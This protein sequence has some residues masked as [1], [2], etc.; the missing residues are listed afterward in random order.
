MRR[1]I[2]ILCALLLSISAFAQVRERKEVVKDIRGGNKAYEKENYEAA[3]LLYRKAL[4]KN[5]GSFDASYNLA[6][7]EYKKKNYEAAEKRYSS[8][9]DGT[10]DNAKKASTYHN[11]GN[12][13]LNQKKYEESIAAYKKAL[14][15]HP[16]DMDTKSNLAY[17]QKMLQKNGGGGGGGNNQQDKQNQQDKNQDKNQ[18]DQNQ[19]QNQQNQDQQ[20]DKNQDQNQDQQQQ[21]G[22]QNQPKMSKQQAEQLLEAIQ[23]DDR[24]TQE[25]VNKEKAR[26]VKQRSIEKNW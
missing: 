22:Q 5:S 17:A 11:I 15:L 21:Q 8:I 10:E 2:T 24:E 26:A 6:N 14:K 3:E 13:F 7:T 12:S 4:E 20:N 25:K 19:D 1:Y 9:V 18:Q 16:N 23:A